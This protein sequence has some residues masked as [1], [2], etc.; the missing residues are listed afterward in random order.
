MQFRVSKFILV[1]RNFHGIGQLQLAMFAKEF[2]A[3]S[4]LFWVERKQTAHD[5]N[6]FFD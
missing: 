4:A 6:N 3:L 2:I 5:T 1:M